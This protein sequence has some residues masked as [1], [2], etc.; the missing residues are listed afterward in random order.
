MTGAARNRGVAGL[1][2]GSGILGFRVLREGKVFVLGSKEPGRAPTR[3]EA[4]LGQQGRMEGPERKA[5]PMRKDEM[6]GFFAAMR[7]RAVR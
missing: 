6:G 5:A 4:V 7:G 1:E 3:D 2:I